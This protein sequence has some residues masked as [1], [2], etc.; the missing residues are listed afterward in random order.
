MF[1]IDQNNISIE[2]LQNQVIELREFCETQFWP[3]I[4]CPKGFKYSLKSLGTVSATI[5]SK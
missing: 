2:R 1:D 3:P 5:F 4:Y